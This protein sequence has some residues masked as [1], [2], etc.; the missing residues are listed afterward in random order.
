MKTFYL[1]N[2]KIF[3]NSITILILP[4]C[5]GDEYLI[6][7]LASINGRLC[8]DLLSSS[9]SLLSSSISCIIIPVVGIGEIVRDGPEEVVAKAKISSDFG[10]GSTF[11]I[12]ASFSFS[13]FSC[14]FSFSEYGL[15][16]SFLDINETNEDVELYDVFFMVVIGVEEF[17]SVFVEDDK[18]LEL[19]V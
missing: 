3:L 12:S 10:F 13:F 6:T 17:T 2:K 8:S 11:S 15:G 4:S 19:I 18:D 5:E 14:I 7:F 9:L 1:K 16:L